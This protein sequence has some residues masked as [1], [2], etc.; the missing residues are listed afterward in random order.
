[1]TDGPHGA[2]RPLRRRRGPRPGLPVRAEGPDGG[3]GHVRR[4]L[5]V[6]R[7]A[8]RPAG[9][10]GAGRKLPGDE[11][12]HPGRRPAAPRD[13]AGLGPRP[14]PGAWTTVSRFPSWPASAPSSP[15]MSARP[16]ATAPPPSR[17]KLARSG[18]A[19]KWVEPATP[20][21]SRS[22]FLGEVDDRDLPKV[23]RA[24]RRRPRA[25]PPFPLRV[26]GR[27]RVPQPAA[28]EGRVGR[29]HRGGR[30]SSRLFAQLEAPLFDSGVYRREAA[31]T[32]R[33]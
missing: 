29:S 9:E 3:R 17:T 7:H 16:S 12:H 32:P 31:A 18:A 4:G 21:T 6:R 13:E 5:P 1:M 14:G 11:G 24:W 2:L 33:T 26:S 20:C 27:R 8:R 25:E 30:G 15:S 10:G 19:V 22:L 28:A 23:C